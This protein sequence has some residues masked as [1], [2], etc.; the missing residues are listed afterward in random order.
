MNLFHRRLIY[1]TFIFVFLLLAPLVLLYASGFRYNFQKNLF[2]K[3]GALTIDTNPDNAEVWLDGKLFK[4]H[5]PT[6]VTDLLP[7]EYNIKISKAEYL[8]WQKKINVYEAQGVFLNYIQL[9]K[10]DVFPVYIETLPDK[11]DLITATSTLGLTPTQEFELTP[12]KKQ[13]ELEAKSLATGATSTITTLP[14]SEYIFIKSPDNWIT[15]KDQLN[16]ILYLFH[17][18]DRDVIDQRQII[19]NADNLVWHPGDQAIIYYNDF[20]LWHL[21]LW[22]GQ[23]T[24]ITRVASG[25]KQ[26]LWHPS[27]RY[28]FYLNDNKIRILELSSDPDRQT[29]T[30]LE[31][32]VINEM[33]INKKG[34]KLYLFSQLGPQK[35]WFEADIQ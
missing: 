30:I 35:G 15:L 21:D 19:S 24:L 29:Y 2:Q 18:D 23:K 34:D 25:I 4:A 11:I 6:R 9:F 14:V 7:K 16:Q 22:S 20:E 1:I 10:K 5:S 17:F 12:I 33:T 3:T 32:P 13:L 27:S 26:A 8:D 28:L 31:M